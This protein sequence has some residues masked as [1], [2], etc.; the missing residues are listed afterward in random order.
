[1]SHHDTTNDTTLTIHAAGSC[2]ILAPKI[3]KRKLHR[4]FMW[5][6]NGTPIPTSRM[7]MDLHITMNITVLI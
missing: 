1:M 4:H 3:E 5:L 2:I 6:T 7:P